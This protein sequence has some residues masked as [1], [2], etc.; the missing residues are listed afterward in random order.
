MLVVSDVDDVFVPL[1]Q[2][3]FVNSTSSRFV[4]WHARPVAIPPH[5]CPSISLSRLPF[6]FYFLSM[7]GR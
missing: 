1:Q 3:M 5:I 7:S 4:H 6:F 2:G